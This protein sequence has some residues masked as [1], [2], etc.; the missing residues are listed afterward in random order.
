MFALQALDM[1]QAEGC[2]DNHV[3]TSSIHTQ[4]STQ[5]LKTISLKLKNKKKIDS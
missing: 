3:N 4:Q 1:S 2:P 5:W